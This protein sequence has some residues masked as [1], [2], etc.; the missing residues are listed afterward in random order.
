MIKLF[1]PPS[2]F[3]D[4]F[5]FANDTIQVAFKISPAESY[6]NIKLKVILP[7]VVDSPLLLLM[8]DDKENVIQSV[9]LPQNHIAELKNITP[10]NYRFKLVFD[11]NVNGKW[12]A[13]NYLKKIQPEKIV[14]YPELVNVR[15]NWDSDLD[16]K[17]EIK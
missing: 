1:I 15:A 2:T 7:D 17:I 9:S 16:W 11:V 14:N 10:G 8:T 13:G 5:G 12:D 4:V 6:G 3:K